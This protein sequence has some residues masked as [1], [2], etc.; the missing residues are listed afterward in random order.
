MPV[1]RTRD[2]DVSEECKNI[3]GFSSKRESLGRQQRNS[4]KARS[5]LQLIVRVL[6]SACERAKLLSFHGNKLHKILRKEIQLQPNY[7]IFSNDVCEL[8]QSWTC[9]SSFILIFVQLYINSDLQF[10]S[11]QFIMYVRAEYIQINHSVV[12]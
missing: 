3:A 4:C 8:G 1:S 2:N 12:Q 9:I 11:P 6:Q 5:V 10:Y 7:V